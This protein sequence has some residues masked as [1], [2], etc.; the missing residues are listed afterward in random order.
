MITIDVRDPLPLAQNLRFLA[1]G[2]AAT[3]LILARDWSDHPL[4]Q[5][6]DW[7]DILKSNLSLI[8]NSPESMILAWGKDTLS[9]FFNE[10]YIPL[11][12][13]RVAWAMGSP[14]HEVWADGWEQAKPIIDDAFAGRSQRF[15]DLPWKLDTDRGAAD[16]WFSFSYS[17][18]LEGDGDIAGLFI[19]TNETTDRVLS[20]A[21]LLRAQA[22][23]LDLN[24]TLEQQ[25]AERTADRNRLWQLSSDIMLIAGFDGT[26]EAVNPAWTR[27]LGWSGTELIGRPLFDFIHPDDLD[28][29]I[30]GARGISEGEV[31]ARFANRYRHKDGSYR[32]IEWNAGPGDGKI[33]AVGRDA[34]EV[35]VQARALEAAEGQ[36]RQAQK[37]E[38]VG[39]LTGG[40]AHDFNNLLT[41]VMG[42]LEL[43]E[44]R[45]ARG[46][47]DDVERFITA[48]QHAGRRAASLTQR[49]LAF[50]RRQ[51]LDPRPTD[52]NRLIAGM[53]DLVRR[54][55]GPATR[56]NVVGPPD[57]WTTMIDPTQFE[58]ALLNLCI[59]ARDAMP[60]G[61]ALT[62]DTA[63]V[64]LD[65][66]NALEH[67]LPPGAYVRVSVTDTGTGM[68]AETIDHAF[69][70][71]F[72]TKPIGQGTGLG[73]SMIYGFARQSGGQVRIL[74]ELG[75]GSTI[76]VYLP[77]HEGPAVPQDDAP[78]GT[79]VANASGGTILLVDDEASIRHLIDEILDEVG[80]TVIGA[81]DGAAGVKVL[82]SGARIDLLIT[83]VGLPNGMNGRQVADIARLLRPDLKVLFITG[84]AEHAALGDKHLEP[85]MELLTKPFSLH[86]LMT[87][88]ADMMAA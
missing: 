79:T 26:I 67:D 66:A 61:G 5:P 69:E 3:R 68:S 49:L 53:E 71:F 6:A 37:M 45:I 22:D 50:S 21:A 41:G 81:A 40:I 2:G 39:Q 65:A 1:G 52:I 75:K 9:F 84:Y 51:T 32:D 8:L 24:A 73:L 16:T 17:R 76:S 55:V 13:P 29:T 27:V 33:I 36:L 63:N 85:G 57:L 80:Y 18:I 70:P 15:N 77:Q 38:A 20:D 62:I 42:N 23:L 11:L 64:W 59:N 28:N 19:L 46:R 43:L 30:A 14:F 88:V 12:G 72:T 25:V 82:Q 86:Q 31:V 83:D 78:T 54:T 60:N 58:N 35:K 56:I 7:P 48:A 34:T 44:L 10:T 87:K 4:G 74:S 47:V